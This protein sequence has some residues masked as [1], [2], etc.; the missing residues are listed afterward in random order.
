MRSSEILEVLVPTG[1][2]SGKLSKLQFDLVVAERELEVLST[3]LRVHE[4]SSQGRTLVPSQLD[5]TVMLPSNAG[6]A[7]DLGVESLKKAKHLIT[8][9]IF[10]LREEIS[11]A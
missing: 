11:S 2:M 1:E 8:C 6:D 4:E 5:D 10:R 9:K 7:P 3:R